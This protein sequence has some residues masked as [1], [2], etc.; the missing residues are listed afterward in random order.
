VRPPALA[1]SKDKT[2]ATF[3]PAAPSKKGATKITMFGFRPSPAVEEYVDLKTEKDPKTGKRK[4]ELT[5][6]INDLLEARILLEKELGDDWRELRG[7]AARD[8]KPMAE[9]IAQ[10]V[11]HGL[12]RR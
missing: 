11:R 10:A 2:V 5:A 12:K 7:L 9:V 6:V 1:K 3:P 4:Y 8:D